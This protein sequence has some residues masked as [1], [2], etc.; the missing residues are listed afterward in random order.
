VA[1]EGARS[2]GHV[3][4]TYGSSLLDPSPHA[5]HR[6]PDGARTIVVARAA[7]DDGDA[8]EAADVSA[9][10]RGGRAIWRT[11]ALT[12]AFAVFVFI[13]YVLVGTPLQ[14]HAAQ[15]RDFAH[16][17]GQL[18]RG[19]A[20]I[21]P[22]DANGKL[23]ALGTP[24]AVLRIPSTGVHEVVGE[25][26]TS[27]ALA[28]GPG[29][30]RSSVFPGGAGTSVVYGRAAAYGGPFGSISHLAKGTR[31]EVTTGVGL[32]VF[33]V[34]DV[35]HAGD[36]IP[37]LAAGGARLTLVTASG[38]AYMP[39][40]TVA[41]DADLVGKPLAAAA[42]PGTAVPGPEKPLGTDTGALVGLVFWLQALLLIVA[43]ATWTWYTR[44]PAHAWL[45]CF[46]PAALV[47]TEVAAQLT[48]LLPNLL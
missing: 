44:S 10:P 22:V 7:P 39:S 36:K 19:V 30:L 3:S 35:R 14:H 4:D 12:L 47:A 38:S 37:P 27:S 16:F 21:A 43:L 8:S 29:H 1:L 23:L 17:R 2:T 26:T 41:V 24:I 48:R 20:P 25:G 9:L 18:A 11:I 46:A 34:V 33:R 28:A 40:G 32:A 45:I 15:A 13:G 5:G 6:D 42:A 31:I